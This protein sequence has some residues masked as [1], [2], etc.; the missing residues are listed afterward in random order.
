MTEIAIQ[1]YNE[2]THALSLIKMPTFE[3]HRKSYHDSKRLDRE[4]QPILSWRTK[5]PAAVE[6]SRLAT[7]S[8]QMLKSKSNIRTL[9]SRARPRT[10][11]IHVDCT[12]RHPFYRTRSWLLCVR[13]GRHLGV[14]ALR[15][16]CT[17][18]STYTCGIESSKAPNAHSRAVIERR[19]RT[20]G[21][22]EEF[23]EI[24]SSKWL[25]A[26]HIQISDRES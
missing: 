26:F 11:S 21:K 6:R 5:R 2:G 10:L 24:I 12:T 17:S 3:T 16:L 25:V 22:I 9:L 18:Y 4:H 1:V 20:K 7:Y 13:S 19:R 14:I 8:S 15:D 23:S